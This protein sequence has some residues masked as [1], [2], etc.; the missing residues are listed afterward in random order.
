MSIIRFENVTKK[1]DNKV[2][3]LKNINLEVNKGEFLTLVGPSGC[4]KT[5]FLKII[6]GIISVNSGKIFINKKEHH[7]WNIIDLRR[8]IGYVIQQ[9]ALFPH[10][11]IKENIAYVLNLKKEEMSKIDNRVVELINLV[12][13]DESYLLRYP[14]EISGGQ[15]QRIG[16]ARALAADPEIILMDE[17]LGAVDEITRKVLQ[18]ELIK[19]H[20]LL[21]KTIVFVTHDL[22]EAFKLGTKV[23]IFNKGHLEQ[24]GTKKDI[25]F[26]PKTKFIE[27]FL[28][29]KKFLLYLKNTKISGLVQK[30]K[31]E[32]NAPIIK[33]DASLFKAL[34]AMIGVKS[35]H[36]AVEKDNKI[37]GSFFMNKI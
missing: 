18:D 2:V 31:P 6:N 37:I 11:T 15:M 24:C 5:T 17:P 14:R 33:F 4:G 1:Y 16:I 30:V 27:S 3:A 32:K 36:V 12:G 22:D 10:M 34:E 28:K 21:K 25:L 19:I 13:L 20:S 8:N 29:N 23:A 35:D 7:E 9:I 26:S